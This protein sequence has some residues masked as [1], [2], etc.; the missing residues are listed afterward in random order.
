MFLS[1]IDM[2]IH[3]GTWAQSKMLALA[4]WQ[5]SL[6]TNLS[7]CFLA[8]KLMKIKEISC[9]YCIKNITDLEK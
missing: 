4:W 6:C 3:R 1:D 7:H 2:Q 5:F 8:C 9:N